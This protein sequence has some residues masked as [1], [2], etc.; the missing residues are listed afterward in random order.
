MAWR[1]ILF[2][3]RRL[4]SVPSNSVTSGFA[5]FSSKSN[6]YIVKVGIPEFL[7]GVGKGVETHIEKL[8]SEIG[9]FSKLLVTRTLKL[10]KLGIPCKHR[11]L[12]LKYTH[13]YRLGLWRPRAEPVK[14]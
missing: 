9:D 5:S 10:K 4:L 11:K 13:K 3:N 6:P 1:Q 8:E 14:A 12:I 7:N 2:S